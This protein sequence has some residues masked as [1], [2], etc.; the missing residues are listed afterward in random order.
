MAGL[1]WVGGGA[2]PKERFSR[3]EMSMDVFLLLSW[4]SRATRNERSDTRRAT[5][6][7]HTGRQFPGNVMWALALPLPLL[8]LVG[9]VGEK[10]NRRFF[11]LN[12]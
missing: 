6:H 4:C 12:I 5:A 7:R 3:V 11:V 9:R 8:P 1:A 10:I 2:G